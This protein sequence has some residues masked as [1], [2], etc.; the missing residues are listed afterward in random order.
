MKI[1]QD[2]LAKNPDRNDYRL[3]LANIAVLSA[4]YDL[5]IG[6]YNN[7]IAKNPQS[8]DLYLRLGETY[9]RA[10]KMNE[11]IE[12]TRKA[13][14]LAP[15]SA[16]ANVTLAVLLERTGKGA[17][18]RPLYEQILKTEP[19]NP[20]ALNN[21]AYLMAETGA[22]LDQALT[23]AQRARQRV[24]TNV[25]IADT[26]GWIYIKKNLPDNAIQIFRDL[27]AK[28]PDRAAFRYHLAMALYQKG[29]K[30]EAK[31]EAETAL[32]SKPTQDEE[33]KIRE[34]IAKLG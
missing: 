2:Q 24:P 23:M 4:Q 20:V 26:L 9:H 8:P 22:D 34:L 29:A 19:D 14:D 17:E 28:N 18:A 30:P 13:R 5:A 21:L 10:G 3:A 32:R 15:N 27:V 7:L 33:A 1:L 16:A 31:K 6:E 12:Y 11:A 25:D